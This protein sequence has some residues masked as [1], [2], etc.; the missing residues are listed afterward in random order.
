MK[1][2][3]DLKDSHKAFCKEY[4]THWNKTKA[5][6]TAYPDCSYDSARSAST[7]LFAN[8]SI[9]AYIEY[10]QE[11]LLKLCGISV[12]S[13]VT[14]LKEILENKESKETDRIKAL[15]V[16]NKMLG[17]NAPEKREVTNKVDLT[18]EEKEARIKELSKKLNG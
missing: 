5:Y 10:I 6:Q 17:L 13:N 14:V 11:D 1:D 3:E 9:Q 18:P 12:L 4:V 15:E 16:V 2:F 8:P 7:E